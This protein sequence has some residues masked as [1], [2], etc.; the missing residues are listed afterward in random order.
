LI[1]P[2]SVKGQRELPVGNICLFQ[3]TIHAL[4]NIDF[5]KNMFHIVSS[6]KDIRSRMTHG[7]KETNVRPK[8]ESGLVIDVKRLIGMV[9][10]GMVQMNDI[11]TL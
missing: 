2:T 11:G 7:I 5:N 10:A 1:C 8:Y 4:T 3:R 9:P 6:D